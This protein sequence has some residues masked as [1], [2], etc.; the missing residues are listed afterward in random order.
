GLL[1]SAVAIVAIAVGIAAVVSALA[2]VVAVARVSAAA[3]A[4]SAAAASP[5][6]AKSSAASWSAEASPGAA[7]LSGFIDANRS[8]IQGFAVH[9]ALRF[10]GIIGAVEFH[11]AKTAGFARLFVSD[12]IYFFDG[13]IFAEGL[14]QGVLFGLVAQPS[15]EQFTFVRHVAASTN[16]SPNDDEWEF[17]SNKDKRALL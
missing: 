10:G 3:A 9:A 5:T 6:P 1:V 12:H 13:S 16:R 4:A 17:E 14:S 11:E 8:A 15:D 7:A 2:P